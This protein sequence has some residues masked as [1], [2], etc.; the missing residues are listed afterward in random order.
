MDLSRSE[1]IYVMSL[2]ERA[3]VR[4]IMKKIVNHSFPHSGK[5]MLRVFGK[6]SV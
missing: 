4:D 1:F 6:R 2:S 3:F 5:D